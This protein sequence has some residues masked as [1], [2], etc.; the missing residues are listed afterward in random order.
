MIDYLPDPVHA[1][2]NLLYPNGKKR[3]HSYMADHLGGSKAIK[4][5]R[6]TLYQMD[7]DGKVPIQKL[8]RTWRFDVYDLDKWMKNQERNLNLNRN[9]E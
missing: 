2:K 6:S 8:G 5:R 1:C 4:I 3:Q 7:H 9:N